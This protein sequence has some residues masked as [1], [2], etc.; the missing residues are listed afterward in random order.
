MITEK[1]ITMKKKILL[2][3][4]QLILKLYAPKNAALFIFD[5][6]QRLINDVEFPLTPVND[7]SPKVLVSLAEEVICYKGLQLNEFD[8]VIDFGSSELPTVFHLKQLNYINNPNGSM[9]WL[10]ANDN[11]N[12]SFLSFYN[13]ATTRAKL[14]SKAIKCAFKLGIKKLIQSGQFSIY[15]KQELKINQIL[16]QIAYNDYSI[17][18]GTPGSNRTML[19]ELSTNGNTTHFV[20]IPSDEKSAKAV[21]KE[22]I[23]LQV[24]AI[25]EFK[26]FNIPVIQDNRF[27][28]VLV[29]VNLKPLKS[30]RLNKITKQHGLALNEMTFQTA[31]FYHLKSSTYWEN[32]VTKLSYLRGAERYK[33]VTSQLIQ[34]KKELS[35]IS[36]IYTSLAHGDFTPWNMYIDGEKLYL[37]DWEQSNT[38]LPLLY[39]LFHFH[40]QT[41]VLSKR[42]SFQEIKNNIIKS[43]N[44][45]DQITEIIRAYDIDVEVYF[46]MYLLKSITDYLLVFQ[47]QKVLSPQH[48]WLLD[49]YKHALN[50]MC[51]YKAEELLRYEFIQEF[52]DQLKRTAHAFLKFTEGSLDNLKTS[53]DID[54]LVLKDD[55]KKIISY[56][57][58]HSSVERIKMHQKSFM[59]TLELFFKD[60][61]F[62]SIDLINQFKRKGL[63]MLAAEPLLLSATPNKSGVFTP[64]VRFDFEYCFL[65][66]T[67]NGASLPEKYYIYYK[68]LNEQHSNKIF[69]YI[70]R[71]YG[72]LLFNNEELSTYNPYFKSRILST[73][74]KSV[75]NQKFTQLKNRINYIVDTL[76]DM[77]F[78][79]G[80]LITFSGVDGAGKTTIIEKVKNRL[81]LK[82]RKE[83]V[84]LRHRPGILP[85]LSAMKHGKE[86]AE[87]I[88]SVTMPRKGNNKNVLSSLA[89]FAYYF[90]DYMIGQVY[91]Y[92]K[93]ILRGKIVLYDRYYFDFI[94]DA[95]RSNIQLNRGFLK[96][97]YRF[98]FKPKLN[99]FLYADAQTILS[100]KKEMV[101]PEI[102]QL[103]GL[104]QKLFTEMSRQYK[105][106]H[107][108]IIE[109][110]ELDITLTTIMNTYAKV[111]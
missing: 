99:F 93:Y 66:Y 110:K 36:T 89:R 25:K 37:Y 86:A 5:P 3:D 54:I 39:D 45:N 74:R 71:K 53:S 102:E 107:Y 97:L 40:F 57:K 72:L 38:E 12:A 15:Y 73:L 91:V 10:Y 82:Y 88:A 59:T 103:T 80:M 9:R 61:S 13:A 68:A 43:C 30:Q 41:G 78:R 108:T 101:A 56:C 20:K 81:E 96:A 84:L 64:D 21:A 62:L 8:L 17:F 63:Q 46:K 111:A 1:P 65:F 95:K 35:N 85:I 76:K 67:L 75:F 42:I 100:R 4:L 69:N 14:I 26:S 50:Q 27:K 55:I 87:Q 106:S 79:Q 22:K 6:F 33:K 16:N 32:L 98:V 109:N 34:L 52:N 18:M 29:T 92:F 11:K 83:V 104:Y 90:T 94:N 47:Q 24:A 19:I 44:N 105:N 31:R 58:N 60:D 23:N 49:T 2:S 51:N 7:N 28:D 70:N 77:A 48:Q